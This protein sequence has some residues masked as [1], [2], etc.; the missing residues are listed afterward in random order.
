[1]KIV[2]LQTGKTS[3][4]H[5]AEGV[6][7]YFLRL[8]KNPGL[9]IITVPDIRNTANLTKEEIRKK[10]G[11]KILG[12]IYGTDYVVLLDERGREFRTVEF[13]SWLEN[14]LMQAERRLLFV[15]GGAWGFSE[16]VYAR[17]DMKISLS[18]M[19]FPHQLV[20]LIFLEQLY[21]ALSIIKGSPYHH[22]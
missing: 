6:E 20:R 12:K 16:Q 4:K 8:E 19:T 22:E 18:K 10:E 3:E 17:A 14:R 11:G 7:N 13:A 15:S 21:R 5:I 2:F 9:E 1:M